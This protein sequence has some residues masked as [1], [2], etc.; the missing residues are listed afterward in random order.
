MRIF[1]SLVSIL[2]AA[3]SITKSIISCVDAEYFLMGLWIFTALLNLYNIF[4][5]S[6][7]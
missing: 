2:L 1:L 4:M 3:L 5:L 7:E 6:K